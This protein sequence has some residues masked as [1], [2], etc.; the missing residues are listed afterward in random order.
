MRRGYSSNLTRQPAA[1]GIL[2]F[3]ML[4]PMP[5]GTTQGAQRA[6]ALSPALKEVFEE[7]VQA[8]KAGKLDEAEKAFLQVLRQGGK[9]AF[10]HNNL[11]IVYQQ[12]RDYPQALEHFREAIRLDPGYPAPRVLMGATLLAL[13]EVREATQA[14]ETAVKLAPR[15]PLAR[16][17]LARA[18]ER[19]SNPMGM[20][21]Q[22]TV[23]RELAPQDPE[24][25]YQLGSAYLRLSEGCFRQ[26]LEF[27]PRSARAYQMRAEIYR[28]R[29]KADLAIRAFQH[30]LEIDPAF[31]GIHLILAQIYLEQGKVAD[32]RKEL[33]QELAVVPESAAAL[34]LK[35][36]LETSGGTP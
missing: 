12:R 21:D 32:A 7:G 3:A 34:A 33:E 5:A 16:L 1:F 14:L 13:G 9:V 19:A 2:A 22:L 8:Q 30:A 11:G 26:I 24:F 18:Y 17:E 15:E 28:A 27:N 25:V 4:A 10:V 20:V 31:P 29:G 36:K 35:K 6:V 23:L